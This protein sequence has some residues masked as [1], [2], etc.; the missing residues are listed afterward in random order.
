[1]PTIRKHERRSVE[2][3]SRKMKYLGIHKLLWLII[4]V[5]FTLFES[6]FVIIG[7]AAYFAWNMKWPKHL[8]RQFHHAEYDVDNHWGGYAYCDDNIWQ[9]ILRRYKRTFE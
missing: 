4:V 8:W 3:N 1:M 2:I 5:A 6:F 7:Y 9:T